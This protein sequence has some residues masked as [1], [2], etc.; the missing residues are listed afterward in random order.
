MRRCA[1]ADLCGAAAALDYRVQGSGSD[2][3]HRQAGKVTVRAWLRMSG[4]VSVSS[5][6]SWCHRRPPPQ[7]KRPVKGP[8]C[9]CSKGGLRFG[10]GGYCRHCRQSHNTGYGTLAPAM[11]ERMGDTFCGGIAWYT[12]LGK[13]LRLHRAATVGW[14]HAASNCCHTKCHDDHYDSDLATG[15][16]LAKHAHCAH[17]VSQAHMP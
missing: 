1:K 12:P 16:K 15:E 9:A 7:S 8:V 4:G 11:V 13:E 14:L 10:G 2:S 17:K 5:P 6:P 3:V